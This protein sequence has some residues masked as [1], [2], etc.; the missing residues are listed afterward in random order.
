MKKKRISSMLEEWSIEFDKDF[1]ESFNKQLNDGHYRDLLDEVI[2]RVDAL[3][4]YV[5]R[6]WYKKQ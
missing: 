2:S 3:N 1:H 5:K 6:P 4:A